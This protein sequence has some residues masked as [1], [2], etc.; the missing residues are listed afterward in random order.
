MLRLLLL[1]CFYIPASAGD[2]IEPDHV[3]LVDTQENGSYASFYGGVVRAR[4]NVY[5]ARGKMLWTRNLNMRPG[6]V[7]IVD[8]ERVFILVRGEFGTPAQTQN[9]VVL[10]GPD[11]PLWQAPNLAYDLKLDRLHGQFAVKTLDP[12]SGRNLVRVYAL[13]GTERFTYDLK[14]TGHYDE[15]EVQFCGDGKALLVTATGEVA[16]DHNVLV[17]LDGSAPIPIAFAEGLVEHAVAPDARTVFA[18]CSDH[19]VRRC[20]D[21]KQV[22]EKGDSYGALAMSVGGR[23]IAWVQADGLVISDAKGRVLRALNHVR[24][25]KAFARWFGVEP[26]AELKHLIAGGITFFG[27]RQLQVLDPHGIPVYIAKGPRFTKAK[28]MPLFEVDECGCGGE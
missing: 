11:G 10:L 18:V 22:E 13:D 28:R 1:V 23:F 8:E 26:S 12:D 16:G 25:P 24:D 7:A 4:L 17:P 21:G 15:R 5:N 27:K 19:K 14:P 2:V 20:V 6:G 3:S 9:Q